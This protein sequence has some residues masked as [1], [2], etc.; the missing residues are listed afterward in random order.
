MDLHYV[1][2][3]GFQKQQCPDTMCLDTLE[4]KNEGQL[5]QVCLHCNCIVPH[6]P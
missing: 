2:G 6:S 3:L 1:G 4:L 5:L